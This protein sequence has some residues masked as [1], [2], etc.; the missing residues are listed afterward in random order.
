MNYQTG[1]VENK[2][3]DEINNRDFLKGQLYCPFSV[4]LDYGTGRKQ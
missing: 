2:P 1:R 4:K 3:T